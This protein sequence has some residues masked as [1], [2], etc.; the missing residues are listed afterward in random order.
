MSD[1]EPKPEVE[2]QNKEP[3]KENPQENQVQPEVPQ[4]NEEEQE[5][6]M[7]QEEEGQESAEKIKTDAA[8]ANAKEEDLFAGPYER[9]IDRKFIP[10]PNYSD[11]KILPT[12]NFNSEIKP[13]GNSFIIY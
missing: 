2:S 8:N 1:G 12:E 4:T 6:E 13:K 11:T 3:E 10:D 7:N 9:L 5:P